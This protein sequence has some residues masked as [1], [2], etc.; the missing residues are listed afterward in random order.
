MKRTGLGTDPLKWIAPTT[1]LDRPVITRPPV[2]PAPARKKSGGPK[3]K[4][5]EVRLT[6]L[7]RDDQ[8]AFLEELVRAV[9]KSRAAD[10]RKERIT[11]NTFI[12]V[13]ID[14]FRRAPL[15]LE[16]VPDEETLLSRAREL[17]RQ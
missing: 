17:F 11:K 9:R 10:F 6:V 4:S 12:R 8:L 15:N 3:F 5:F 13:F 16:N 1:D 14:A 2:A 7:L